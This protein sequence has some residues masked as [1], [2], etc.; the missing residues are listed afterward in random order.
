MLD[1]EN[2]IVNAFDLTLLFPPDRLQLVSPSTGKS[3]AEVWTGPP[4]FNNRTGEIKFQGGVPGG[5]NVSQ[6][7]IARLTFRVRQVGVAV[8]KVGDESVVLLHD[9]KGTDV[10][11]QTENGV[12]SLVLPPPAGP[13]VGSETHPDQ[14]QWYQST[15]AILRWDGDPNTAGFSYV[16]TRDP[17]E[18]PDNISEGPEKGISYTNL[19][20]GTHYFHIKALRDGAWGGVTHFA[21]NVDHV[22]PAAFMIAVAPRSR[23]P[24]HRPVIFFETTDEHSGID[25]YEYK[26]V[27]L[28]PYK[29]GDYTTPFFIEGESGQVLDLALGSYDLVVRA[30]DR[31]GNYR[32]TT[33]RLEIVTALFSFVGGE[34]VRIRG[35]LIVPWLW[36]FLVGGAFLAALCYAAF[37]IQRWHLRLAVRLNWR[38]ELPGEV[39]E[40]LDEL[41]R[42]REKYGKLLLS[43]VLLFAGVSLYSGGISAALAQQ[44]SFGPPF[45]DMV[46][47]TISN[48]EIFYVGGKTPIANAEVVLYLQNLRSGETFS[49]RVQSDAENTWFYRHDSLLP[50][51]RYLIWTQTKVG[52]EL[53]PPSPQIE[54]SVE[55]TAIQFGASRLSYE[56]LY[57]LAA[58]MLLALV[59]SLAGYIAYHGMQGRKK[60]ALIMKEVREAEESVRRGFAVLRRDIE[61]ELGVV[62]RAKLSKEL[63]EEE[64]RYEA[65]LMKDLEWAERYIGKEVWDVGRAEEL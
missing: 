23:T 64:S 26:V 8:V 24:V 34:G 30:Y 19:A 35:S 4:Q 46:S 20:N 63:S 13:L 10:L 2:E 54:V 36:I 59:L 18:L 6:G 32:E 50:S 61:R 65:E 1:T 15:S 56:T 52:D 47:R 40:K 12:Y 27:S 7:L 45:V 3:I 37:H 62:R 43:F 21:I 57:F 44:A 11:K 28:K 16:L 42:Y 17:I 25:H 58:L 5:V 60:R 53:S 33:E 14:A 22:P 39:Q 55:P 51:G 41:K 29:N 49:Y 38:K 9:G 31:A 48:E